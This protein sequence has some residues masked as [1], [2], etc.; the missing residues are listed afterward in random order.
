[1]TPVR[2]TSTSPHERDVVVMFDK[3]TNIQ[4]RK[5]AFDDNYTEIHMGGDTVE[6]RETVDEVFVALARVLHG[7]DEEP[8]SPAELK[9]AVDPSENFR[10]PDM[11][12]E[13]LKRLLE[14][15]KKE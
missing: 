5:S 15:N 1:M 13:Q 8:L 7:A 9:K 4:A 12:P 14:Q 10:L 3:I 2:L 6:V 11:T